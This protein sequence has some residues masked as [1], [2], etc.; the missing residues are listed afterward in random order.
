MGRIH[1]GL[2]K[3]RT[4]SVQEVFSG[5]GVGNPQQ[6]GQQPVFYVPSPLNCDILPSQ[7]FKSLQDYNNSDNKNYLKLITKDTNSFDVIDKSNKNLRLDSDFGYESSNS[8][9][10][11]GQ[12]KKYLNRSSSFRSF[13]EDTIVRQRS[14]D[15]K[16]NYDDRFISKSIKAVR[17]WSVTNESALKNYHSSFSDV[18]NMQDSNKSL[19]NS[20]A[21]ISNDLTDSPKP[22]DS[23]KRRLPKISVLG[24]C[25]IRTR[26]Y[27]PS[28]RNSKLIEETKKQI[29]DE[30]NEECE[31]KPKNIEIYQDE[32][33]D[34]KPTVPDR[35]S[36]IIEVS[37]VFL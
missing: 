32:R 23:N 6:Q 27:S 2:K 15:T 17:R 9:V 12:N 31:T 35:R 7:D 22:Q 33:Q 30:E 34:A 20:N 29:A 28:A 4:L 8:L 37:K 18:W 16:P 1:S 11:E 24:K 14:K 13:Q 26:S 3:R 19:S 21:P 36:K 5:V 10:V 25:R